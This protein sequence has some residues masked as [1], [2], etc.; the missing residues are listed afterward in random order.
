MGL[1]VSPGSDGLL[2]FMEGGA[3]CYDYAD[4]SPGSPAGPPENRDVFGSI[5]A[6]QR[7]AFLSYLNDPGTWDPN[8]IFS[9]NDPDNVFR[10]FTFVYVIACTGDLYAGDDVVT[11]SGS[12]DFTFHH[13]GQ[14]NTI[15]FLD[16]LA[17]T[18]PDPTRVVV[19]GSSLGGLG[20]LFNY[21]TF[22]QFWPSTKM[23]LIDDSG[24]L[25]LGHPLADIG[26]GWSVWNYQSTV[27]EFCPACQG[28]SSAIY[29]AL[30]EKYPNDRKSLLSHWDDPTYENVD[31]LGM[32]AFADALRATA[33]SELEPNHWSWFFDDEHGHTFINTVLPGSLAPSQTAAVVSNGV[34]VKAFLKA[35]IDDDPSWGSVPTPAADGGVSSPDGAGGG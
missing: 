12:P 11:Y 6:S 2:F 9:R 15:A 27:G 10:N 26:N 17:A 4:C 22:R 34:S 3:L 18:W 23:Y 7:P 29:A 31:G 24:T 16:R 1:L 8:S 5:P 19:A 13:K 32:A 14:A 25:L 20:A 35:Q 33:A 21:D 30:S 28:D